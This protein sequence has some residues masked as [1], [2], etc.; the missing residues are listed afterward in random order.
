MNRVRSAAA[1]ALVLACGVSHAEEPIATD[2][3][4]FVESSDVVGKGRFQI[5][6]SLAWERDKSGGVSSR[7]RATPTLLR[8][9][10]SDTFELR[11]ETD[12]LLRTRVAGVRESGTADAAI[13]FKWH[14]ADGEG[15]SPGMAVLVHADL[16]SGSS[17]YRGQG[18]RPS[19]RLVAEWE[20]AN[21]WSL[22]VMPGVYQDRND[23]GKRYTGLIMAAVVGKSLTDQWRVFGELAAQQWTSARNG[24]KVITLD[25]GTAYLL[26][27]NVQVDFALS[28]GLNRNTPDWGWTVGLSAK[29]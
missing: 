16:D 19:V 27:N 13:G 3:P 28:R 7:A 21:E 26:T 20:L 6:T 2:R 12:G 14:L 5:E 11:L 1:L 8:L 25:L 22:G 29:F 18:T 10:V 4:D 9:G 15:S 23:D 17:A 24:G